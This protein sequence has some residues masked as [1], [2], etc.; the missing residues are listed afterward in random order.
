MSRLDLRSASLCLSLL[1]ALSGCFA[2]TLSKPRGKA[3][4][5]AL[6]QGERE[7]HHGLYKQAADSYLRAADAAERRV[8]RD[9]ALYRQSRVLAR[10]GDLEQAI[11]ICDQIGASEIIARRTLRARLDAARYRLLTGE[12]ERA[13]RDLRELARAH[14]DS[15]AARSAL[16]MLL[17]RHVSDVEDKEQ[18]LAWIRD[19]RAEVGE[20]WLGE[21]LFSE[22][23]ELL[24]SRGQTR[25]AIEV[26][27]QQVKTYPYP[28]G[29]RWEEAL[30]RMADLALEQGEP[31]QA[32][33]YLQTMVAV[34]EESFIIGSYTR[35]KFS[36]AAIRIARIYR[37]ELRDSDAAIAAY[38]H[39]RSEFPRSIVIDDALAEEAEL[40]LARGDRRRG[41]A[42]LRD[43]VEQ[44]EV[45][46]ARRRA[47]TRLQSDCQ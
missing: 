42:M 11:A 16:R 44:F 14:A 28:N 6:A 21:V 9:E 23:A 10:A 25:E 24:A 1:F 17:Q 40:R 35:P 43:L 41:C 2:P 18:A 38:A 12:E 39:V 3:H 30:W 27:A 36:K 34:H 20:S 7:Q 47:Q 45:G 8:D 13:D 22:E 4:L 15:A 19:F 32:I 29:L 31:K 46:S 37:D 33:G 5:D 26:F